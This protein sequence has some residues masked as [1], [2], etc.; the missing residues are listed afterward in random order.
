MKIISINGDRYKS[1]LTRMGRE[2]VTVGAEGFFQRVLPIEECSLENAVRAAGF[3]PDWILVECF[4]GKPFFRGVEDS[5]YPLA[6]YAVDSSINLFWLRHYAR[7]F[8]LVMVDQKRAVSALEEEGIEAHWLPLAVEASDYEGLSHTEEFDVAFVGRIDDRR[9]KRGLL[10]EEI[11]GS[12]LLRIAGGDGEDFLPA[13]EAAKFYA[14]GRLGLN[15]TI[16]DGVTQRIFEVMASGTMLLAERISDGLDELFTEGAHLAVFGPEDLH[17]KLDYYLKNPAERR[18]IAEAGRM[19]VLNSHTNDCRAETLLELMSRCDEAGGARS[20]IA[21]RYAHSGAAYYYAALRWAN[22]AKDLLDRSEKACFK[23]LQAHPKDNEVHLIFGL[24]HAKW[25]SFYIAA[26][27]FIQAAELNPGD[28]RPYFYIGHLMNKNRRIEEACKFFR[29]GV[30]RV[31]AAFPEPA[32]AALE[33]L[34]RNSPE[35]ETW[36]ALG[37]VLRRVMPSWEPGFVK[38][39]PDEIPQYP[40]EYFDKAAREGDLPKSW[41][42]LGACYYETGACDEA[43]GCFQ[44]ALQRQP[45]NPRL[46][47]RAGEAALKIYLRREGLD[48]LKKAVETAPDL[49]ARILRLKLS[50]D[51]LKYILQGS[52]EPVET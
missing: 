29:E 47:L 13:R 34:S 15:E 51:E 23:A 26:E 11:G 6:L 45:L 52:N 24:L 32:G 7:L 41:A 42:A 40:A 21:E 16:F 49:S 44:T 18:R 37:D 1:A 33:L 20:D 46:N 17:L 38:Y 43:L 36:T 27:H 14:R 5:E 10:L 39:Q 48:Y 25:G 2:I 22:L 30:M 31:E 9:G 35:G 4:G 50:N 28:Y 12:Y 3:E 19:E 8:D